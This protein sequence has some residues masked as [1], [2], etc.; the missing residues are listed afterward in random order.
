MEYKKLLEMNI[1]D[2]IIER[3]YGF[4][5]G[6]RHFSIYHPSLGKTYL[7]LRLFE[8]LG[9]NNDIIS[10]NPYME[11]LR[12]CEIKRDV[13][14]RILAYSTFCSKEDILDNLKVDSRASLFNSE[15]DD[16]ELATL[17]IIVLSFDSIDSYIQH[18]GIDKDVELRDRISKIRKDSGYIS[19]GGHSEYGLLI[20]P[21]CE[22]YGWS[23]DY[24]LWD[25]SYSNLKMLM[26]DRIESISLSKEEMRQLHIHDNKEYINA[27]DPSNRDLIHEMLND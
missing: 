16:N 12:L 15:L 22:R 17:F 18:F 20:D 10:T 7:L 25:I 9:I 26:V 14:C 3:P 5:V 21:I 1:A 19:L 24:V 27:D 4:H 8:E 13:V 23:K 6:D 11:V 2:T